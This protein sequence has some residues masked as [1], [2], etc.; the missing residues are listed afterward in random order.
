MCTQENRD[1]F[2]KKIA[3]ECDKACQPADVVHPLTRAQVLEK[4]LKLTLECVT[5]LVQRPL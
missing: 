2:G 3:D 4:G 1:L 5:V